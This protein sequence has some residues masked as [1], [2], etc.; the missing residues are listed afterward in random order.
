MKT[1]LNKE[2][3]R[4]LTFV[5]L[6][7]TVNSARAQSAKEIEQSKIYFNQL[8]SICKHDNGKIWGVSLCGPTMLVIPNSRIIIANQKDNSN[9]L[10]E[11]DGAFIGKLPENI[12]ISNTS[13]SWN[14]SNWTMV[15]WDAIPENDQYSRNK[16][17]VHE[18]WHRV[19]NEIGI[20]SVISSN[21][22]L[23]NLQG[24]ILLKLEYIILKHAYVATEKSD[25]ITSL[26][27]ALTVRQYRQLIFRDNN[28]NKF[29][30]HEGMAEYTGFKL[31]GLSNEILR[32]VMVKQLNATTN[33]EG[34]TN[35]FAYISGPAYGFLF[36]DLTNDWLPK[37]KAGKSLPDIG[38]SITKNQLPVDT[39]ILS[40]SVKKI[41]D[42]YNAEQLVKSETEKFE[43]QNKVI[44]V[45]RS[46]FL[47]GN[48]LIIPNNN[49]NFSYNPQEPLVP[50]DDIGVVYRT[51]RLVGD[52]GILEI[53]NG[54]LRTNDWKAFIVEAPKL[55]KTGKIVESSYKIDLKSGWSIVKIKE[56]KFTLQNN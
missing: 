2:I 30:R 5:T 14:G 51:M 39:A 48:Q 34:F 11:K 7:A 46:K 45:Y 10:K 19:Q 38:I 3:A 1:T 15:S 9:T 12:N 23:D 50:I 54:I 16:L 40:A 27:D 8:D 35:S 6:I 17:L 53:T 20:P 18:S 47:K 44:E 32:K 21:A 42:K 41:I 24:S 49:V 56:G 13:F 36:D 33:K 43:L 26:N 31:C 22:H 29:E 25:K 37:I 28:E 52:W 55:N 4:L